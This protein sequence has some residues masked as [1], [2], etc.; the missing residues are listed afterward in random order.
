LACLFGFFMAWGIGANDVANSMGTS[1]GSK[2]LTIKQAI[3]IACVFEFS[4]AFF[5][6]GQVASTIKNNI[7]DITNMDTNIFLLGM[8][9]SLLAS[10]IWLL[11]AT[12][13]GWPVS[14]THTIIGAIVGFALSSGFAEAI[15]WSKLVPIISSWVITPMISGFI[16][17]FVF[18]SIQTLI[19]NTDSPFE[20]A[21]KYSPFYIFFTACIV[22][23][24]TLTKGLK[25]IGINL[26][27]FE[28]LIFALVFGAIVA[29]ASKYLLSKIQEKSDN[30]RFMQSER[31]F[32][33]LM[34]FTACS[35]AFAH[36][37]ND[38][39]NAIGPVA[40][41]VSVIQ[42]GAEVG[43]KAAVPVWVLFLGAIG[44]IIGLVTYGYKLM[45]TIGENITELTPS[46]GFAAELSTSTTVV[47]ASA[48]GLPISTT[49]TLV[50][51][52]L[53]I[54]FARGIGAINLSMVMKIFSS[55]VITLPA[56]A[57]LAAIFLQILKLIF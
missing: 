15:Y 45:E 50:G 4:G 3:I 23:F 12:M 41:V 56:G 36:G 27:V 40:A 26:T 52:I 34:I 22:C 9:A 55:W 10:G 42:E 32:A 13:K 35:M 18:T 24:S 46:R 48:L 14:T 53:G 47:L 17:F 21:K 5:A 28:S 33:T 30:T 29:L 43:G 16:A 37:A 31:I 44:I 11:V 1:V 54:G 49:H 39:S 51:A 6:G 57:L 25:N 19:F 8:I 38:V 2:V 20:N 7:I